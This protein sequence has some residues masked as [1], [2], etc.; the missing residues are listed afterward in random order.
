MSTEYRAASME[1]FLD[2]QSY[3]KHYGVLG[4]KW[5][6]RN[7]ETLRKYFGG[8]G[9]SREQ[10]RVSFSERA[11][12]RLS[13][14]GK[15]LAP[16]S[17]RQVTRENKLRGEEAE[18]KSGTNPNQPA[19]ETFDYKKVSDPSKL[20]D[21]QLQAY[22]NRMQNEI[23][24]REK[25]AKLSEMTKTPKQKNREQF[26]SDVKEIGRNSIKAW[27]KTQLTALLNSKLA[28]GS[29]EKDL[30]KNMTK[31]A[32]NN[33][34]TAEAI[35]TEAEAEWIA[36]QTRISKKEA[37]IKNA[38]ASRELN[39]QA[40]QTNARIKDE[41]KKKRADKRAKVKSTVSSL[42]NNNSSSS[43]SNGP[44]TNVTYGD[45][46]VVGADYIKSSYDTPMYEIWSS[47]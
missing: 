30:I 19:R 28:F 3:L 42:L 37:N 5:G 39:E 18:G 9:I 4:M 13:R 23:S 24:F 20:S 11:K 7:D 14:S 27:A 21:S 45:V 17:K 2:D 1:E 43:T 44:K 26:I 35:K 41:Q 38:K 10:R 22:N 12:T 33:K 29:A 36:A 15:E 8:R 46:R 6:V 16:A 47:K 40:R 25:R 31:K 32:T 34:L